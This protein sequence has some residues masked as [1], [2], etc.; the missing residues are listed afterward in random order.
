MRST[1]TAQQPVDRLTSLALTACNQT[2]CSAID[3][4]LMNEIDVAVISN[5]YRLAGQLNF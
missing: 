3:S 5:D 1:S 4:A 2:H